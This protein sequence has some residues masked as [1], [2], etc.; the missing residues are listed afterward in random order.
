[1]ENIIKENMSKINELL[2]LKGV[3]VLDDYIRDIFI[4]DETK[5]H[6]FVS[7]KLDRDYTINQQLE[8]TEYIIEKL[9]LLETPKS[10]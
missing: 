2:E 3:S 1:M 10:L 5:E 6:L 4:N 9:T 8:I 7:Q